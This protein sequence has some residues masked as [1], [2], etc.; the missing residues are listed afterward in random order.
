MPGPW[1]TPAGIC[2]AWAA[3]ERERFE[4]L[5]TADFD[6]PGLKARVLHLCAALEA[7]LSASFEPAAAVI[8]A[9]LGPAG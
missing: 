3:F 1:Q 4:A 9:S 5:A 2:G 6:A 8:K 7:T